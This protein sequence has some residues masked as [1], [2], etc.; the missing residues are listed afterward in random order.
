MAAPKGKTS[1]SSSSFSS[2]H[3]EKAKVTRSGIH[4]KT[5]TSKH[6]QSKNYKKLSRGQG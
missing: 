5:K 4:A 2:K 6:K 1:K 3:R